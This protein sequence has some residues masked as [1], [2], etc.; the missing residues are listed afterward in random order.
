MLRMLGI[1]TNG[2]AKQNKNHNKLTQHRSV[3][4]N[5]LGTIICVEFWS[6][7]PFSSSLSFLSF[8]F[9]LN[10]I[11]PY[12]DSPILCNKFI[13]LRTA[14]VVIYVFS[15]LQMQKWQH[16]KNTI[17]IQFHTLFCILGANCYS[18]N[19]CFI[20]QRVNWLKPVF[21]VVYVHFLSQ[22]EFISHTSPRPKK[23]LSLAVHLPAISSCC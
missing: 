2:E 13:L 18:S 21:Y 16:K 1:Q 11:P 19:M 20:I 8:L 4:Q 10:N 22:S 23:G 12:V 15:L 7:H 17:R 14:Q 6:P 5:F 9:F 3:F